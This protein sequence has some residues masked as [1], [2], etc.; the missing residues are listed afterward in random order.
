MIH[1]PFEEKELKMNTSQPKTQTQKIPIPW[2]L[3]LGIGFTALMI[4]GA[5]AFLLQQMENIHT[6]HDPF[7]ENI[8]DIEIKITK[9]HLWFEEILRLRGASK[10]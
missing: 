7:Y 1:S 9:A 5:M 10:P 8:S 6:T 3:Y 4:V 2:H